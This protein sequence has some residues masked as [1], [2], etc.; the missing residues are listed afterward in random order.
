MSFITSNIWIGGEDD[1]EDRDFLKR[2]KICCVVNCA[3]E[4]DDMV[5]YPGVRYLHLRL[6]DQYDQCLL[7]LIDKGIRFMRDHNHENILVNCAMGMS[8]SV[9]IALAYLVCEKGWGYEQALRFIQRR[10]NIA[11][12]NGSFRKQLQVLANDVA[13]SHCA[14]TCRLCINRRRAK[15]AKKLR[16]KNRGCRSAPVR[17]RLNSNY[18]NCDYI[19]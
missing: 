9:S 16:N 2:N 6:R 19:R 4:I 7:K 1:A 14:N 5:K 8:R 12:P 17:N 3:A 11:S 15:N 18:A 13:Y 10:R